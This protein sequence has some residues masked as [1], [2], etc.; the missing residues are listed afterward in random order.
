MQFMVLIRV[1]ATDLEQVLHHPVHDSWLLIG[2]DHGVR[3]TSASWSLR[4]YGA[5]YPLDHMFE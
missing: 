1:L 3:L 5:V 4:E 2:P